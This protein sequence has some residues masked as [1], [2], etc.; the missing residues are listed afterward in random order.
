M[1]TF[2]AM[3]ALLRAQLAVGTDGSEAAITAPTLLLVDPGHDYDASASAEYVSD[4]PSG[5]EVAP[6]GYARQLLAFTGSISIDS[7]GKAVL[8][9]TDTSFGLLGGAVDASIGG[10]YVFDDTG[11]D[12]TSRLLYRVPF[13]NPDTTDGTQ[14]TVRWGN[15]TASVAP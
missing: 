10:G 15:P 4:L 11:D 9:W 14:Y 7:D 8:Q 6:T 5:D 3:P 13:T 12:A 1:A 2:S